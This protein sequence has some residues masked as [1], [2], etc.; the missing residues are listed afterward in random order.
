MAFHSSGD[1]FV[2]LLSGLAHEVRPQQ[3]PELDNNNDDDSTNSGRWIVAKFRD[4]NG[5]DY[6]GFSVL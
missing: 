5:G 6:I 4:R 1:A 2:G 3:Q